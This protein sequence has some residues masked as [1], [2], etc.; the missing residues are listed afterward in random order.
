MSQMLPSPLP[1][2]RHQADVQF[3]TLFH[4]GT[5]LDRPWA[6]CLCVC[7]A[8]CALSAL[9]HPSKEGR[10]L[11]SLT[12]PHLLAETNFTTSSPGLCLSILRQEVIAICEI[13]GSSWLGH[14]LALCSAHVIQPLVYP[15]V[16]PA[17]HLVAVMN[18]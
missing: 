12:P 15:W 11:S 6:C 2:S 13:T 4:P 18:S 3:S 1:S 7:L 10:L 9:T 14:S 5:T 16:P 8:L 17:R